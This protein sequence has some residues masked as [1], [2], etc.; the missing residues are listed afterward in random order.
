[1][2]AAI[3][4]IGKLGGTPIAEVADAM[5]RRVENLAAEESA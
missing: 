3:L 4:V 2:L 5:H 1:M